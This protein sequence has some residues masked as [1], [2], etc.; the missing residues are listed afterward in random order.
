MGEPSLRESAD[1]ALACW[2][3]NPAQ[4]KSATSGGA[5][6]ILADAVLDSGGYVCGAVLDKNLDVCHIVSNDKQAVS[7][8]IGSK[9]SQSNAAEAI[10]ECSARLAAGETVL[11]S[12]TPCQVDAMRRVAPEEYSDNLIL[13]DVVCHGAPSPMFWKSYVAYR[14]KEK[15]A[16]AISARFR[17]KEPSW[18]VFSLEMRFSDGESGQWETTHDYYLRAFLGDYISQTSCETC[19]Y[20]GTDRVSD[21]TLGDFWGYV[22]DSFATRNTEQGISLVLL[23]SEKGERLFGAVAPELVVVKK[24]LQEA[25]SGNVPLRGNIPKNDKSEAFWDTFENEGMDGVIRKFLTPK[26]FGLKHQLSLAFN[27]KAYLIPRNL[28]MRL[29]RLRSSRK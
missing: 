29:I 13:V 2:N 20:V 7:R 26:Q 1:T 24:D 22:S 16:N 21:I 3:K 17:K 8:M 6:G 5:F 12:G 15:S 28:R 9:Y 4:R 11:F 23:N 18:T 10:K 19:P 14:E 27:D 25:V